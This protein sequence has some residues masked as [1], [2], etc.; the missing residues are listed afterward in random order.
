MSFVQ[1]I[2]EKSLKQDGFNQ[3]EIEKLS[4]LWGTLEK[5]SSIC[6]LTILSKF[7]ISIGLKVSDETFVNSWVIDLGVTYHMTH[8]SHQLNNYNPCPNSKKTTMVDGSLTTVASMEVSKLV[9]YSQLE[10]CFMF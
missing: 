3:G 7:P 10:F 5:P 1:P 2:E 6:S 9:L 4:T 8:S